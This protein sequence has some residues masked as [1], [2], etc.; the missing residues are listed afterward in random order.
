MEARSASNAM[1][2]G[3]GLVPATDVLVHFAHWITPAN[4]PKRYDT[5]FFLATAPADQLAL[6]DGHEAVDSIWIRPCDAL[7]GTE[8]GRFKL[9]FATQKNLE[10]LSRADSVRDALGKAAS[11]RVVTV[12][13]R[14]TRLEGTRRLLSIPSEAGYGGS[15]FIVDLPPAS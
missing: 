9:V 10:K 4:Q 13:P 2:K 7:A 3:E 11:S 6:H 5:Q 1:L 15:G 12:L 14:G 8:A